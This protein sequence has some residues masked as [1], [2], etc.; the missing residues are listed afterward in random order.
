[1]NKQKTEQKTKN[2]TNQKM[3]KQKTKNKTEQKTEN[4]IKYIFHISDI[5]IMERN[6][7]N[8]KS[9]FDQL[10]EDIT[11]AGVS[12]SLLIIAG[13]IFEYKTRPH[14]SDIEM[15][16]KFCKILNEKNIKTLVI[17]GNHDYNI[18]TDDLLDNVTLLTNVHRYDNIVAVNSTQIINGEEFG[19]SS[20]DFYMFS[21]I[22]RKR[23]EIDDNRKEKIKIAVLHE[24]IKGASYD[25][26]IAVSS[27]RFGVKDFTSYDY[28]MLGDIH[29]QQ[30]LV[31]NRIAY[32]GSFVQ[33][34]KK[35]SINKG[36][37]LWDLIEKTG[38]PM[39]IPLVEI[40]LKIVAIDGK[41]E[42][43]N[44]QKG[45]TVRHVSLTHSNC[46]RESLKEIQE[47]IGKKFNDPSINIMDGNPS[48][49]ITNISNDTISLEKH[50]DIIREILKGENADMINAILDLHGKNFNDSNAKT[51]TLYK[52]NYLYW[53]NI[54]CYGEDNFIDFTKFNKNLVML[55][56]KNKDGKSSVMDILILIL[57]NKCN[58]G[59]K[60]DVVNKSKDTGF[61]KV[62]FTVGPNEYVI[63]QKH[64]R[65]KGQYHKLYVRNIKDGSNTYSDITKNKFTE[66]YEFLREDVG[67]G[68]YA[69]FIN[70][71]AAVQNRNS[72]VDMDRPK[73]TKLLIN[74]TNI[75][76][77]ENIENVIK[78]N[79]K[80]ITN[81]IKDC[82]T[83]LGNIKEVSDEVLNGY[84]ETEAKLKNE[85]YNIKAEISEI[86]EKLLQLGKGY[87]E[88]IIPDDLEQQ[89]SNSNIIFKNSKEALKLLRKAAKPYEINMDINEINNKLFAIQQ[90]LED[91]GISNE[92]R[93]NIHREP[94]YTEYNDTKKKEIEQQINELNDITIKPKKLDQSFRHPDILNNIIQN[95]KDKKSLSVVDCE[96]DSIVE[97]DITHKNKKLV[98]D[99]LPK[100][101]SIKKEVN[102][103]EKDIETYNSNFEKMVY[104]K[105][106]KECNLNQHTV[107]K[108][109]DIEDA[110]TRLLILK[111]ILNDEIETSK[112][113]KLAVE[114][115][116]NKLQNELFKK[117]QYAIDNNTAIK[118]GEEASKELLE[119]ENKVRYDSIQD[120][121]KQLDSFQDIEI[122][123]LLNRM[124]LLIEAQEF[125]IIKKNKYE[126]KV[127]WET[128]ISN[129]NKQK[130]ID[131]LKANRLSKEQRLQKIND[132]LI[133]TT[134]KYEIKKRDAQERNELKTKY[135]KHKDEEYFYN[136]YL[137]VIGCKDGIP[138]FV[139]KSIC[140]K[141][142]DNCNKI[143]S[144]ITDFT[145]KIKCSD[146]DAED[147]DDDDNDD[148]N[149]SKFKIS[150][151][152]VNNCF[153]HHP[154]KMASG[155]QKFVLDLV[156]RISLSQITPMSNPCI[157]FIDEGFGCL[158]EEN[159]S[160]VSKILQKLKN[161]FSAIV[162]ISHI[163]GLNGYSDKKIYINKKNNMSN[164][165]YGKIEDEIKKTRILDDSV[166]EDDDAQEKPKKA[167]KK[168][169]KEK[170][171]TINLSKK[172]KV[173]IGQYIESTEGWVR[174]TLFEIGVKN[175]LYCLV[176]KN[177][178]GFDNDEEGAMTHYNTKSKVKHDKYL[179][180]LI[181]SN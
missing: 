92:E 35:E 51:K 158:D 71:T 162:I 50:E 85:Q 58:R 142:Q 86:N 69:N 149:K 1:M 97:L 41:C 123:V 57:F 99:G 78:E 157:L 34:T 16:F 135:D 30:F 37:I 107:R 14:T 131:E 163:E 155:M 153:E 26:G 171:S 144:E 13:D 55:N 63:E 77:L 121:K 21:P 179:K 175:K 152:T 103:I 20:I 82:E 6:Y 5:H 3:N 2:E 89:I 87:N 94:K 136:Q 101:E 170:A 102:I 36:Y 106:C 80:P 114:Y 64:T 154:A 112:R 29:K 40:Y 115:E 108:I 12:N 169:K 177:T 52:L 88:I 17:C 28:V 73:F 119:Y 23:L 74:L 96:I 84:K 70:M 33:K 156:F 109:F 174:Q 19:D 90:R 133:K 150:I 176:C 165:V 93:D 141:L 53:S 68:D 56:G 75:D 160:N 10:M 54:Y 118:N 164:L 151:Y 104:S 105:H 173:A 7:N 147:D 76:I 24:S 18:N 22:D 127:K 110:K 100:Y 172:E 27:G 67:L 128:N 25:D 117:K 4:G 62:S 79:I 38:Q 9:S 39:D 181:P 59:R 140:K 43:P 139:L 168:E 129:G 130:N 65:P 137:K 95:S 72:F 134:N 42:L 61:I 145:V 138:R 11:I 122:K 91:I 47:D 98:K 178:R 126:L 45:Q 125:L 60:C 167:K 124:D 159:F 31:E 8:L 81:A 44:I 116:Y 148:D 32:C 120:F 132:E 48:P 49:T 83:K 143:L 166:N 66:T 15:W 180:G 113:Y 146:A 111:Q 46:T 161:N